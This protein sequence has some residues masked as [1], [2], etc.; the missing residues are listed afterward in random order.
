MDLAVYILIAAGESVRC[1]VLRIWTKYNGKKI[2]GQNFGLSSLP[3][4]E[5]LGGYKI[6]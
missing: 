1:S 5:L 2:V 6:F 4:G 3:N